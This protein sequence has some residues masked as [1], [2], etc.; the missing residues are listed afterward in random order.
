MR[1]I[2]IGILGLIVAAVLFFVLCTFTQRPWEV[3]IL[4]RAG[5]VVDQPTHLAYNLYF[6]LPI[7]KVVRV[8]TRLHLF[9]GTLTEINTKGKEPI[10]VQIFAAW[11]IKTPRDFYRKLAG[12][13]TKAKEF[14]D[15][16]IT[17]D[18][19]AVI[20]QHTLDELYNI[21]EKQMKMKDIEDQVIQHAN[22]Q[23]T[24]VVAT[25]EHEAETEMP[26]LAAQGLE[27][28][29]VG[30][31]RFAFP[32]A[33][34]QSV[35]ER[36]AAERMVQATDSRTQGDSESNRLRSEGEQEARRILSEADKQAQV[37]RGEG[38]AQ[39]YKILADVQKDQATRELYSYW[40]NMEL[41]GKSMTQ[42]SYFIMT[43]DDPL[44]A[45]VYKFVR[46][47]PAATQPGTAPA[48]APPAAGQGTQNTINH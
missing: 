8:D 36:M 17:G 15:Q 12:S 2:V 42:R 25:G 11:R 47:G 21:D 16:K 29:Q 7:D 4:D 37:I 48:K 10:M 32:P 41:L 23:S 35:Y 9:K 26:G 30:F 38:T 45:P 28:K 18:I 14:I 46:Q 22:Q 20:G 31:S 33:V 43:P 6:C 13:D 39:A 24:K 44:L 3:V 40:K 19:A 27:V 1:R 34:A 5:M